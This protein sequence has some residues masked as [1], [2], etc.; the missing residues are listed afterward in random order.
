MTEYILNTLFTHLDISVFS[1]CLHWLFKIYIFNQ[2][3]QLHTDKTE[4]DV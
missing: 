1:Y 3:A 2:N 4:A